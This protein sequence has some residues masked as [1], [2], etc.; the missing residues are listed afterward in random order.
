MRP[1]Q[2]RTEDGTMPGMTRGA[3]VA[4]E[5]SAS[6]GGRLVSTD[7]RELVLRG[8]RLRVDAAGGIARAVLEQRFASPY[9][10]PLAFVYQLPLPADGAVAGFAFRIGDRLVAGEIDR[11]EA[12]RRRFEDAILEGR[13]AALLEQERSSLFTQEIGNVPPRAEV[14]AE[15]T[16][17]QKL[18]WLAE[19]SWEWRFPT[20]VAPRYLGAPG[21]IP[22]GDRITVDVL[23][24]PSPVSL[25]FEL[26]IRDP[27]APHSEPTSPSH[28]IRATQEV[29]SHRVRFD[30]D[31]EAT[32]DR[33][34][35]VRWPV[36]TASIGV[37]L[38]VARRGAEERSFG[39]LTLVP[40][41]A[42][43]DVH[44]IARD[45]VVLIDASGSMGGAPLDQARS[46]AKALVLSLDARDTLELIA[47]SSEPL[48]F[49]ASAKPATADLRAAALE[50]LDKLRAGG[51][52]EMDRAVA[53]A[54]AP[55]RRDA[56]RQVVL[57][58]DG[59][60]GFEHEVV[61]HVLNA[62]PEASR[63]H[64]VGVGSAVNRS[65]TGAAARAGRGIEIV[66]GIEEDAAAA[67]ERLLA[68]I[69][70][71]LV[72]EV[73]ILGNAVRRSAPARLRD[74][75]AGA[76]VLV[77]LELDP[78]GGEIEIRGRG[79]EQRIAAPATE[80]ATV[81]PALASLFA[82]ECVEDL[83]MAACG[84]E[85]VDLQIEEIGLEF[86]IATRRTSWVAVSEE[87][88][89]DPRRPTRR[90]RIAQ[91]IPH[92]LSVEGLGLR[93][94][95]LALSPTHAI[96]RSML[97]LGGVCEDTVT[98]FLRVRPSPF[99]QSPSSVP[100]LGAAG[101]E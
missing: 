24:E 96:S 92:G 31:H 22:D 51:G 56:Q 42:A 10:E 54:L 40:P 71:P 2:A 73:E 41:A 89:V 5:G 23:E 49:R 1:R 34:L 30:K 19:G 86:G 47:F 62:L 43:A 99:S 9:D 78:S 77:S 57:V 39:L 63:L 52:T 79:F 65:L 33:D 95:Q 37:R 80:P 18:R 69:A 91:Q 97:D 98:S 87:P 100:V 59:L 84:G 74:L 20:V 46:I 38:E 7:G 88:T 27:L 4:G 68:H 67:A 76:P 55:L 45:L 15:I 12:A 83:E 75:A 44:P 58:T 17:D 29:D 66:V 70:A 90:E 101:S 35:V 64:T 3:A 82:R 11:C 61:S 14:V 13:T 81:N 36:A 72:S 32:L 48:R 93:S 50:W 25:A 8:A 28:A 53:A 85:E 21:H 60:I 94:P 6:C 26:S 16:I